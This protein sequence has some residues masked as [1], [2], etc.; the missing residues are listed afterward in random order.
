MVAATYYLILGYV[1]ARGIDRRDARTVAWSVAVLAGNEAWNALLFGRR[2]TRAA[3]AGLLAFLVPLAGLQRSVWQDRRS[4]GS[5]APYS[6]YVVLYDIPW[7][8]QLWRRNTKSSASAE[9][10]SRR[11]PGAEPG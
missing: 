6:A 7:A 2:S 11:T 3:F 5:L 10:R 1:L 4:W 9:L 8:Y